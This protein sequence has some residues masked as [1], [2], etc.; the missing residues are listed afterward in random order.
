MKATALSE[1]SERS[2]LC[3]PGALVARQAKRLLLMT[4]RAAGTVLSRRNGVHGEKIVRMHEP[5][6]HAAVVAVG[7]RFFA[8][9]IGT[10]ATVIARDALVPS[11]PIW[12]VL[13]VL[14]PLRR[15]QLRIAELRLESRSIT[16]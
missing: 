2:A 16:Q 6:P 15:Q 7:A 5:W 13:R 9:T 3:D 12:P 10:E 11:Q 8:V 14:H 4:A 1:V